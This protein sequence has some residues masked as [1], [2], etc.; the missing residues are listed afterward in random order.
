MTIDMNIRKA[1]QDD[2]NHLA[3]LINMAGENLP[4]SLWRQMADEGQEA[5]PRR[6]GRR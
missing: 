4:E 6:P 5:L 1:T 2:A 3:I